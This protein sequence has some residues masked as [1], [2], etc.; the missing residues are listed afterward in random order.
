MT[1]LNNKA[2]IFNKSTA[3]PTS[4]S[5]TSQRKR[6]KKRNRSIKNS[7]HSVYSNK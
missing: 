4:F 7:E 1:E 6:Y 2:C 5:N 3:L